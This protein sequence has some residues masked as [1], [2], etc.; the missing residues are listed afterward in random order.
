MHNSI[1]NLKNN[2]TFERAEEFNEC[3]RMCWDI[4]FGALR[5]CDNL[6]YLE[7]IVGYS[8]KYL[9]AKKGPRYNQE[10]AYQKF[11]DIRD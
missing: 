8:S 11:F 3:D 7:H 2:Y 9:V 5:R 1:D 4:E 10:W 6:L